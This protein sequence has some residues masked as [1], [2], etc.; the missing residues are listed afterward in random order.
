METLIR[1]QSEAFLEN[2]LTGLDDLDP[3]GLDRALLT[4]SERV[5]L[6]EQALAA[7]GRLQALA[8]VLVAEAD[9]VAAPQA[10]VGVGT[11]SWL[12]DAQRMTR[13]EAGRLLASAQE[14][15]SR[16][17]LREATLTG[18]ATPLQ[19]RAVTRVLAQLPEDLPDQK[20]RDAEAMM[21]GFCAQFDSHELSRLA[22]HLL[23][24]IAPEVAEE[25]L[26]R[27]LERE[28]RHAHAVRHL[29][30]T[31]DGMGSVL[32]KGSL[33]TVE[34]ELLRAQVEA[35]AHLHHRRALDCADPLVEKATPTQRRA[36]AL[37][38]LAR[39]AGVHQ[40]APNHG[41]DRPRIMVLIDHDRL[42]D[43]CRKAQLLDS[44]ADLTPTQL[45]VL[46]C[47]AGILPVV[48]NGAGEVLDVGRANR[49][50]TPSIRAALVARD[51]GCVFPGCDRTAAACDAH[52]ITPWQRG[53]PTSLP[54]LVLLCRHHHNT[55]EPD[56]RHPD[57]RWQIRLD[58]GIPVVIPPTR[59][60]P[61]QRPRRNQRH[62]H[63]PPPA[64]DDSAS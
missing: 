36:D 29:S 3:N 30:F 50:V 15:S 6:A 57:T 54:N 10:V 40:D 52:H 32:I 5:G 39:A 63:R 17:V 42:V 58:H 43:D 61:Q 28:A 9:R 14:L 34:A 11:L 13:R 23:E 38:E 51:R 27:R 56:H 18:A 7:A 24:V 59:V 64:P 31:P 47:D 60:D 22:R 37:V 49:L 55:V 19:A 4:D 45:R 8:G 1:T 62:H 46:A 33:P 2:V 26:A 25:S 35:I 16:P 53:G 48:M 44:G 12:H 41:G 21:V 20:V